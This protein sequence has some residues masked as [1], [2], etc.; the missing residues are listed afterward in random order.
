M[1]MVK[2][3]TTC[4]DTAVLI[5]RILYRRLCN[6]YDLNRAQRGKEGLCTIFAV[7]MQQ[8][9]MQAMISDCCVMYFHVPG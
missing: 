7:A 9:T 4:S 3:C 2:T 1:P 5:K 8:P 6:L